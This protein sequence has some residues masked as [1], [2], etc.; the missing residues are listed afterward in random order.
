MK[1][2][3][4]T[5]VHTI[6]IE[7]SGIGPSGLVQKDAFCTPDE[8]GMS[9]TLISAKATL[10]ETTSDFRTADDVLP[11][12]N[13][14][15]SSTKRKEAVVLDATDEPIK[16]TRGSSLVSP[17]TKNEAVVISPERLRFMEAISKAMSKELAP[18]IV[19]RDQTRARPTVYKDTKDDTVDGWPLVWKTLPG[20]GTFKIRCNR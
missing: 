12:G 20:T 5:K 10:G 18:L 19:G 7:F 16:S 6:T 15:A 1:G 2:V 4:G 9:T 3:K 13:P 8:I 11:S 14:C 17:A